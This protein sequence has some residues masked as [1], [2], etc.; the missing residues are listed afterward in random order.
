M[1]HGTPH[2]TAIDADFLASG[3]AAQ[4]RAAADVL[5]GLVHPAP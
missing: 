3:D 5:Q 4:I 1:H 2:V